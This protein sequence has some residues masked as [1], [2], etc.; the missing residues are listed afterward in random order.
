M[1]TR[2]ALVE[3]AQVRRGRFSIS[4]TKILNTNF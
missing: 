3:A 1:T 2:K 4:S